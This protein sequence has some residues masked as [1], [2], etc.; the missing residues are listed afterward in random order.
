ML[1][2]SN[3]KS[4]LVEIGGE[5]VETQELGLSDLGGVKLENIH[6]VDG[7]MF[8]QT[9]EELVTGEWLEEVTAVDPL[10][11]LPMLDLINGGF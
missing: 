10:A 4:L 9:T 3:G 7:E 8:F 6:Y 11:E 1:Y 2:K 5:W